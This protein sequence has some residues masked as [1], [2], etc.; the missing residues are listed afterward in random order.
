VARQPHE[1]DGRARL[2]VLTVQGRDL[3]RRSVAIQRRIEARWVELLGVG[4]LEIVRRSLE[5]AVTDAYGATF[6]PIRPVW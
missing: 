5:R 3:L 6:P 4:D 2:V 1:E